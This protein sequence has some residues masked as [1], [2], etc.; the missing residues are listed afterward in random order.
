M[1]RKKFFREKNIVKQI[2][3]ERIYR[4]FE[5]AEQNSEDKDYA[6][7]LIKLAGKLG[8]RNKVPIPKELREKY[9]RECHA[10]L[11][12]GRNARKRLKKGVQVISCLECKAFRKI[13]FGKA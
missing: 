7:Q 1:A 10:F 4:L 5:L 12:V 13:G 8:E 11:V 6:K 2:V 9:C 3:L